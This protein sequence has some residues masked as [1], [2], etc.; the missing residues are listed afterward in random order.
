MH[1]YDTWSQQV[2]LNHFAVSSTARKAHRNGI[3]RPKSN[4]YESL[5]GVCKMAFSYCSFS[6]PKNGGCRIMCYAL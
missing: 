5:K 4:R 6:A 1:A 3:K 2:E